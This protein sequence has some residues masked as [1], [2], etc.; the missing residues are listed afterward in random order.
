MFLSTDEAKNHFLHPEARVCPFQ[1][2]N[3]ILTQFKV[4]VLSKKV[5]LITKFSWPNY[6]IIHLSNVVFLYKNKIPSVPTICTKND[7]VLLF[8]CY[9]SFSLEYST[10]MWHFNNCD[11]LQLSRNIRPKHKSWMVLIFCL[12]WR[13]TFFYKKFSDF[14]QKKKPSWFNKSP[15]NA[16]KC[17]LF[18]LRIHCFINMYSWIIYKQKTNT[19]QTWK[20]LS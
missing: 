12:H 19:I 14:Y 15:Q 13:G 18:K 4:P 3:T 7:F 17:N 10:R 20:L 8:Y 6:D 1:L 9:Q 11:D 5:D 16:L 2:D